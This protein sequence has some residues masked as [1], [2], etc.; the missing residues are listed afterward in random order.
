M[1]LVGAGLRWIFMDLIGIH[2]QWICL[3]SADPCFHWCV[4]TYGSSNLCFIIRGVNVL[5]RR[6]FEVL[7]Q[8]LL[9]CLL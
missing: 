7:T 9:D 4:Y 1:D 2:L 5:V 3:D 6:F 8:Q